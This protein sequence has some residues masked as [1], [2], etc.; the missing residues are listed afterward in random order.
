MI[1]DKAMEVGADAIGLSALLVSTSKQMPLCLHEL[2]ARG[3]DFPVLIGGAAINRSFGRR[4]WHLEDGR[5]YAGGV[6]YC[7]DAFEGLDTIEL[8]QHARRHG[9]AARDAPGRR[10]TSTSPR[11]RGRVPCVPPS[12]RASAPTCRA[13]PCRRCRSSAPAWRTTSRST[14]SG[15]AWT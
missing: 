10:P 15:P 9:R 14:T 1:L 12:S 3:L 7:T 13:R 4:I 5:P 8:L 2:D 6:F 11:C